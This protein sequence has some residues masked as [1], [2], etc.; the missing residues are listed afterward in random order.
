[1]LEPVHSHTL[2]FPTKTSNMDLCSTWKPSS[3]L[4]AMQ[5]T[6]SENCDLL[7]CGRDDLLR[8]NN[9]WVALRIEL[10]MD[11]YPVHGENVSFLTY[12]KR[13]RHGMYP[14]YFVISDE[15]GETIGKASSIWAL[16]DL[17][18]RK[19]IPSSPVNDLIPETPELPPCLP[20][21]P[22][23]VTPLSAE[24]VIAE[25]VPVYTD[26][27]A[28]THVNN[29]RYM[30]WCCNALGIEEMQHSVISHFVI[31]YAKEITPG[32]LIRTELRRE[33]NT[34]T[35]AGYEGDTLH[36]SIF[37]ELQPRR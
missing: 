17:E 37:G 33:G 16:L 20:K 30:D 31:D 11:R 27:D 19:A 23:L 3:F 35:F 5:E 32:Q 15:K 24:P 29:A 36:F 26:L 1:M 21:L 22:P 8:L 25:R 2:V 4:E 10:F 9:A 34:F 7:G 13:P 14:R 18:T 6:A 28:N 12:P